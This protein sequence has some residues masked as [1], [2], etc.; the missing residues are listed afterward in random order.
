[1]YPVDMTAKRF[2][3]AMD[4][5]LAC[6]SEA[7]LLSE[8]MHEA[9]AAGDAA[10]V[11]SLAA[12]TGRVAE[13]IKAAGRELLACADTG[14]AGRPGTGSGFLDYVS[15]IDSSYGMDLAGKVEGFAELARALVVKQAANASLLGT[16][17]REMD[18]FTSFL[19][20]F[21]GGWI[22]YGDDGTA[23][24]EN[25]QPRRVSFSA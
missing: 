4:Q 14:G 20:N 9:A 1:M 8:R 24:A 2:C 22:I 17:A 10:R 6:M 19:M 13:G 11:S 5:L 21:M 7:L 12:Q 15:G 3:L 16:L 18:R 23:V 25:G